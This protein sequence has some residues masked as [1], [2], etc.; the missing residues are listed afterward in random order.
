[1]PRNDEIRLFAFGTGWGVPFETSAPFPLKLATWLRMADIPYE[2]VEANDPSKGPKGKAPW[3]EMGDLRMGDST[4][5]I[6]H[7]SERFDVDFDAGLD[8]RQRAL[9]VSVQRM[10]EEHYHQCFEH[11]LFMGR[12]GRERLEEFASLAPAPI[13]WILPTVVGRS[14]AKQLHARGMGRHSEEVIIE[15]GKAD[16]DAL[17]TL[18]GEATYFMGDEPTSIDTC[19]FGFLGVSVYVEGDNPLFRYAAS[20]DN[21]MRYCER[22]RLRYFPET[23]KSLAPLFEENAR[24]DEDSSEVRGPGGSTRKRAVVA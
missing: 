6:E 1:M 21:L 12:G 14:F 5:I 19:I 20:I 18:L 9:A 2:F 17:S 10:L 3:I 15:Q 8:A 16:L 23:T 13:S 24:A 7:L 4:L 22:M 11:Q